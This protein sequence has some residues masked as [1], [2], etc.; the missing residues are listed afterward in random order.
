MNMIRL[1]NSHSLTDFQRNAR[2]MIEGLNETKEPVLLTV[3]GKVEAVIID[4]DSFDLFQ[5][6][7]EDELFLEG[8]RVGLEQ[9]KR[10]EGKPLAQV[11]EE[12]RAKYRV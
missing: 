4:P 10:G 11:R 2:A 7:R 3:N 9:A 1:S 12:I 8:V 5:Q 6:H